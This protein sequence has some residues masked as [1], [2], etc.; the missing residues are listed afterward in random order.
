MDEERIVN[1]LK[2]YKESL[3]FYSGSR[4]GQKLRMKCNR[5]N[6]HLFFNTLI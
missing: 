6:D 2:L 4:I 3:L 1:S 5:L